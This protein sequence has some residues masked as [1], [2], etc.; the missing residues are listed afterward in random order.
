MT[1]SLPSLV[2]F[3]WRFIKS[4]I[5]PLEQIPWA[6]QTLHHW[7]ISPVPP[8]SVSFKVIIALDSPS[9]VEL[10]AGSENH[11]IDRARSL[12]RYYAIR[13]FAFLI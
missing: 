13:Q 12:D 9:S 1:R 6:R 10:R 7:Q 5:H 8:R 2:R 11:S 4:S 3:R